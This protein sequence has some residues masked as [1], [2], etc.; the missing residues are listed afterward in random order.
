[1]VKLRSLYGAVLALALL[2]FAVPAT[3]RA[4]LSSPLFHGLDSDEWSLIGLRPV[5]PPREPAEVAAQIGEG[6]A[7]EAAAELAPQGSAEQRRLLERAVETWPS[8]GQVLERRAALLVGQAYGHLD[9]IDP[10]RR[11]EAAQAVRQL[12]LGQGYSNGFDWLLTAIVATAEERW[13]DAQRALEAVPRNGMRLPYEDLAPRIAELL[14]RSGAPSL[15]A[16]AQA[17]VGILLPEM[18]AARAMA[19]RLAERTR[20]LRDAGHERE[21]ARLMLALARAGES[22]RRGRTMLIAAM[23]GIAIESRAF[24]AG[25]PDLEPPPDIRGTDR[26]YGW[27]MRQHADRF[28]ARL[29][30]LGLAEDA[31][32]VRGEPEV[33]ER[34][35]QA[36]RDMTSEYPGLG[37]VNVPARALLFWGMMAV[38]FCGAAIVTPLLACLFCGVQ[39]RPSR[40]LPWRPVELA[41]GMGL[42]LLVALPFAVTGSARLLPAAMHGPPSAAQSAIALICLAIGLVPLLLTITCWGLGFRF[43][44]RTES[45]R[46]WPRLKAAGRFASRSIAVPAL[47]CQAVMLLLLL[48]C[49]VPLAYQR[50][51]AARGFARLCAFERQVVAAA[52]AGQ[53][54]NPDGRDPIQ[55]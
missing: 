32:W 45:R 22:L 24:A 3:R 14:Q 6:W 13:A 46:G 21:A 33:F 34:I 55:R 47:A 39:R 8:G 51:E 44:R 19:D 20:E 30:A 52:V 37:P 38:W 5:D 25:E 42:A 26:E 36:A 23:V 11:A 16:N 41:A 48:S 9:D 17:T 4:L 49:A 43:A 53:P 7:Y 35:R 40:W 10:E 28:A 50:Y 1:M 2:V 12:S 31:A 29:T 54:V 27:E 15:E 18:Q